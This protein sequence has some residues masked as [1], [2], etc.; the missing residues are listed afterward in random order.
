[1]RFPDN[2]TYEINS[3]L[4]NS[5]PK[6]QSA[7]SSAPSSHPPQ[8]S[9]NS[10]S[11]SSSWQ[12]STP[13]QTSYDVLTNKKARDLNAEK[14]LAIAALNLRN[15][16]AELV[17]VDTPG[18]LK[19]LS[20]P[21]TVNKFVLTKDNQMIIGNIDKDVPPKWL[22]HP[23]IAEI[24]AGSGQSSNVVSAGYIKKD[25]TGQTRLSNTSGHYQPTVRDLRPTQE[26]LRN[27]GVDSTKGQCTIA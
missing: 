12:T 27:M 15:P 16:R 17:T 14:H 9:S 20:K 19:I 26:H 22:S 11:N 10:F 25:F 4:S 5:D 1:M 3:W 7:T 2:P 24:G 6:P 8:G 18:S 23:T 13:P 21:N